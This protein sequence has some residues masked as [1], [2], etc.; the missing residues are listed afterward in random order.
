MHLHL[1]YKLF[2]WAKL[3]H[4]WWMLSRS[5]YFLNPSSDSAHPNQNQE[6]NLQ[7]QFSHQN[8]QKLSGYSSLIAGFFNIFTLLWQL[9]KIHHC[10]Y[11]SRVILKILNSFKII[12]VHIY[13]ISD[14]FKARTI[15]SKTYSFFSF[16]WYIKYKKYLNSI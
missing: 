4:L 11:C 7:P 2:Q 14:K 5:F 8:W 13:R 3:F 1:E 12:S 6:I 10:K 15:H 9:C 16:Y